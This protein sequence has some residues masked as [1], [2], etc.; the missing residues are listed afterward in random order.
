MLARDRE[1]L[2]AIHEAIGGLATP[3]T[4]NGKLP[5]YF[6]ANGRYHE[7]QTLMRFLDHAEKIGAL[8]QIALIEEPF[9]EA[10]EIEVG[11]LG[12]R[13]AADESA[14]TDRDA[15]E[16]IQMGYGAIALKAVAKT[17]SMTLKI[18]HVAH[19][20]QVPCFC[21][22]LTVNPILLEWNKA[23]A[24]R[25]APFP[26]LKLGLLETN[27]QQNY[28]RW[29]TMAGYHP[30][31][32]ASWTR[33]ERGLFQLDD[34]YYARSG[35]LLMPSAHYESKLSAIPDWSMSGSQP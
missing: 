4:H 15:R 32:G 30:C 10:A 1:R 18:A 17:L 2:S 5:Y 23:V 21:A 34:D 22:D 25:L 3:H 35:G 29:E 20:R 8:D 27:G 19:A 26:G 14:H 24:A 28:R 11:D 12:V 13:I 33:P 6:D 16:R 7:K 31:A 9:P